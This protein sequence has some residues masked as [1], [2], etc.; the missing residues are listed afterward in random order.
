M[1]VLPKFDWPKKWWSCA[2]AR[3]TAGRGAMVKTT[4]AGIL[5]RLALRIDEKRER[6]HNTARGSAWP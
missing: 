6:A 5:K 3:H 2:A 1:K 4:W